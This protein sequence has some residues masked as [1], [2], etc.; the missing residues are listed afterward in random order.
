MSMEFFENNKA[1]ICGTGARRV[2][3][4]KSR[5]LFVAVF[6]LIGY[7]AVGLRLIDLTLLQEKPEEK[8]AIIENV[9][10]LE[11]P[12]RA[13]ILDRNGNLIATS[14]SM[15]S[16]Y[17]DTTI[18]HDPEKRAKDLAKILPE[19][20]EKEILKKLTSG[21]K[22]IWL[23]RDITPKQEYAIN[24]LGE[25]AF[26][27]QKEDRRIYPD[28]HLASHVIG[29]TDIDGRGIAGI[30][31]AFEEQLGAG[32]TPVRLTLDLRIQHVMRRELD[33]AI[34]NF[35]AKAGIGLVM[36]VNTG[37]IISMVS[38]PDFDPHY[39]GE[40]SAE[41]KFNNASLGVFEMGSTF[42]LFSTAAALE[43]GRIHFSSTYDTREPI[44]YGRF[45]I[46]DYHAKNRVM[47]VPEIFIYSSNIGTAR[48]AQDVG[49]EK[50]KD[51]YRALGFF[52]QAPLEIPE[53]GSPLYPNPW[54]DIS[55]L[56]TSFGHGIAVSPVH[57]VRAVAAL[58]NGGTLVTPTLVKKENAGMPLSPKGVRVTSPQTS[59][60]VRQLMELVVASGTGKNAYVEGYN[61]GGKTGTSEK[62]I[63][64]RYV[65]N[66]LMSSFIGVF[67]VKNPRYAVLA[68]IDEPQGT[69]ET[70]GYATGGWT[71]APVV[72]SVIE[73]MG[74][75]YQIPPDFDAGSTILKDM[76]A[77]LKE[78]KEGG[79]LAAVGTD[80]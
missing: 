29:Y 68:I 35:S 74:P 16:L 45:T 58:V 27:F 42:K 59:V 64:G 80:R 14:L 69:K 46:S 25:P 53:R 11:K 3:Q 77:Y 12:L 72:A 20:N 41:N 71:A 54:R 38:L 1:T 13:E 22:F 44:R 30:E 51:F 32:Q 26:G 65:K 78:A 40:A 79:A 48:M 76:A 49:S 23:Q 70:F 2:A 17:A 66:R 31:R 4:S 39:P 75:L 55:T 21:K 9:R 56:T 34:K 61:V 7:L 62:N 33:R 50:L 63:Q 57:L 18:L 8:T 5:L 73:A 47:T 10:P 37:E 15:A 6:I 43:S 36:D 52:E 67:P 60:L 19:Q 24:A 28:A